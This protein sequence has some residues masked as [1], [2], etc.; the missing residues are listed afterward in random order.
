MDT[1]F[2]IKRLIS[3]SPEFC[4]G[5]EMTAFYYNLYDFERIPIQNIEELLSYND[6]SEISPTFRFIQFMILKAINEQ[7]QALKLIKEEDTFKLFFENQLVN[8][9]SNKVWNSLRFG[10]KK[11]IS[12]QKIIFNKDPFRKEFVFRFEINI[13]NQIFNSIQDTKGYLSELN[14]L[15]SEF[16][17]NREPFKIYFIS[18]SSIQS[19]SSFIC[20]SLKP[21]DLLIIFLVDLEEVSG[22]SE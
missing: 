9:S 3:R 5:K 18:F 6:D 1:S 7:K 20:S 13:G 16:T 17:F 12:N 22:I 21:L 11:L 19:S 4:L 2:V 8:S 15:E 14:S 10:L